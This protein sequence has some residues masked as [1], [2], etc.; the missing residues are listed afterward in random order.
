MFQMV[1]EHQLIIFSQQTY[2]VGNSFP[3][4]AEEGT[5]SREFSGWPKVAKARS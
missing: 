5:E 4:F 3:L 1:Y 2:E